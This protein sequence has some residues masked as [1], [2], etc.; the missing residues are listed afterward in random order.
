MSFRPFKA[1][2]GRMKCIIWMKMCN[3]G[4]NVPPSL[5]IS[6]KL[7]QKWEEILSARSTKIANNENDRDEYKCWLFTY[8]EYEFW[9]FRYE[10]C[11]FW[12]FTYDEYKW[13]LFI[14]EEYS[15][16]YG[17]CDWNADHY[18]FSGCSTKQY[19]EIWSILQAVRI[20]LT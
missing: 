9:L 11:E 7:L 8:E 6:V 16:V 20:L 19:I 2:S 17:H 13:W 3:F 1:I 14:Y 5:T 10:E 4:K 12:L 18:Y 15:G